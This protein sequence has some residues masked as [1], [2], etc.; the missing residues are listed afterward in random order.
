MSTPVSRK[1]RIRPVELPPPTKVVSLGSFVDR[2]PYISADEQVKVDGP[3][4]I[5]EK[6]LQDAG[7]KRA[8]Q[9]H[10]GVFLVTKRIFKVE[11]AR[12]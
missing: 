2:G 4:R 9:I 6:D 3:G 7:F 10:P 5:V 12:A 11:Y 8:K 1:R